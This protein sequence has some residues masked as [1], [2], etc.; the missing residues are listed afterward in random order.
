MDSSKSKE[1]PDSDV[2]S[3]GSRYEPLCSVLLER[4]S[5]SIAGVQIQEQNVVRPQSRMGWDRLHTADDGD[6]RSAPD[7]RFGSQP[8]CRSPGR[9]PSDRCQQDAGNSAQ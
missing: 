7:A 5:E 3:E 4:M 1:S 2:L 9:R 6:L 8:Q